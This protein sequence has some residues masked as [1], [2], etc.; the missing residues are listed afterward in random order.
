MTTNDEMYL[1]CLQIET[2]VKTMVMKGINDNKKIVEEID[3]IYP[4][5][6]EW[7]MEMFSEAIIFA[8]HA[9]LN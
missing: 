5:A 1:K 4:P 7:E 2:I 9:V 6:N 3:K 8:K